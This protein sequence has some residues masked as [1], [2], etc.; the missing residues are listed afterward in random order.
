M[1]SNG[2]VNSWAAPATWLGSGL[3]RVSHWLGLPGSAAA[4]HT[5]AQ[6]A[7]ACAFVIIC[8]YLVLRS[9]RL[10]FVYSLGLMLV[11]IVILSPVVQPWYLI[12]GLALLACPPHLLGAPASSWLRSRRSWACPAAGCCSTPLSR[13][14]RWSSQ[15]WPPASRSSRLPR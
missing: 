9:G 7:C 8:G 2:H 11:T 5:G 12:W 6:I 4:W 13:P 15:G 3:A 1:A 10:G 14:T